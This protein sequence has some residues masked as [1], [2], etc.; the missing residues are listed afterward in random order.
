MLQKKKWYIITGLAAIILCILAAILFILKTNRYYLELSIPDKTITLEYGTSSVPE[1]TALCK[2]TLLNK[3]GT[4]VKT[5]MTGDIDLKK[6]GSYQVTYK[7]SYKNM[8]L[9]EHRTIVVTDTLPPEI[10]LVSDPEHYTSP[11][12]KYVEEGY[13]AIDNYDGD[14]TDKVVRT[15]SDGKIIYTVTDSNGNKTDVERTIIYKDVIAPIITLTG[16]AD[17]KFTIGKAFTDPGFTASDDVDGDLTS[18]VLVEGTVDGKKAGTYKLTYTVADS[19]GNECKTERTVKVGD[20]KAPTLTLK[21][22][23]DTY[24]KVGQTYSD[25][26]FTASDNVDGDLTAKVTVSGSVN[27][28]KMGSNTL[29]YQ[30]TDSAGNQT[31]VIRSVYV[32]EKQATSNP[33]DPGNKVIYLTFDDGPGKYTERLLNILDKYNVKATFFVTN[34][35]PSY[36]NLIGETHRRGH[37]V[38]LHTYS[39]DYSKIYKSETA[40]YAD[41]AKIHDICVKQTG[42]VP[43]IVRFPGGTANGVSKK[44]CKGI[45]TKISKNLSYH[46][47]LY[48]DWNVDS[49]DAAG[50]TTADQVAANVIAGVKNRKVSVVLQHDIKKYSVDAVEKIIF[51]GL[52]NGYTFLPLTNDSPMIHHPANN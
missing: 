3:N 13:M 4:P 16:G 8:S 42:A 39:H 38:A 26:G 47:Y 50:A 2:G 15:E 30:V 5:E 24:I 12:A 48:C 40:Y 11:T 45:M 43:T 31:K 6:L 23:T 25:P 35:Y 17:Y 52:E 34:Q 9:Y 1:V 33:K 20:F 22:E 49:G 21:G 19:S 44:Y 36:K 18:N 10:Q 32:Y 14:I 37:T 7:A 51:W 29:T 41:L 28:S 46:G 27:T